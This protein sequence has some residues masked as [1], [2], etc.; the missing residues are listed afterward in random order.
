M[1]SFCQSYEKTERRVFNP[2]SR[3]WEIIVTA[4]FTPEQYD[5]LGIAINTI[6]GDHFV[7]FVVIQYPH[8]TDTRVQY[9]GLLDEEGD[10]VDR[11]A[12][13]S[14]AYMAWEQSY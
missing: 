14:N 11:T 3:T 2:S 7:D 6:L 9:N 5:D 1:L 10:E 12:D 8:L 4:P 13:I